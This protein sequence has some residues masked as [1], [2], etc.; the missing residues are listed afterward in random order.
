MFRLANP[1]QHLGSLHTHEPDAVLRQFRDPRHTVITADELQ[2]GIE[3][4]GIVGLTNEIHDQRFE[5]FR[6]DEPG[7]L[8]QVSLAFAVG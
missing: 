2:R 7:E 4:A 1:P 5:N 6:F 8:Q 3:H